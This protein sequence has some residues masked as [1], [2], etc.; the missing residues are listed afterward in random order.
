[1][2]TKYIPNINLHL[3]HLANAFM[4]R[5]RYNFIVIVQNTETTKCN[6]TSKQKCKRALRC[7]LKVNCHII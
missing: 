7:S 3:R 2:Y 5:F 1:M 6:G 4:Q